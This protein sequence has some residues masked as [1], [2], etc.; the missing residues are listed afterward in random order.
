M[1]MSHKY[2]TISSNTTTQWAELS[3]A[4]AEAAETISSYT[5]IHV[6]FDEYCHDYETPIHVTFDE[7]C[8]DYE[9]D[10][11]CKVKPKCLFEKEGVK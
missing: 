8:H 9:I 11:G 10:W 5:P 1:N 3:S 6:T 2:I 7:Y 4:F